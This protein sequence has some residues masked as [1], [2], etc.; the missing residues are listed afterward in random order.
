V[1]SVQFSGKVGKNDGEGEEHRRRH[2]LPQPGSGG[3]SLASRAMCFKF[4]RV[5]VSSIMM[6]T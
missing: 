5:V 1:L 3:F 2:K 6:L 4:M